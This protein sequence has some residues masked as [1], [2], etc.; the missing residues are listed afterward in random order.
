MEVI[1]TTSIRGRKSMQP[2]KIF[3]SV[4]PVVLGCSALSGQRLDS[5][6]SLGADIRGESPVRRDSAEAIVSGPALVKHL[7]TEGRGTVVLYLVNDGGTDDRTCSASTTYGRTP[8]A[9]LWHR[10]RVTD[11]VVPGGKRICAAVTDARLVN[12]VWHARSTSG[13][14]IAPNGA[15]VASTIRYLPR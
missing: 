1:H 12:V 15:T 14:G 7:E 5:A 6:G 4:L 10:Q 9:V 8:I 2:I 11:L 13:W 3:A